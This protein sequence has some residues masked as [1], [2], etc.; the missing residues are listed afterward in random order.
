MLTITGI[1]VQEFH[2]PKID[3]RYDSS[4][5]KYVDGMAHGN[6]WDTPTSPCGIK[7]MPKLELPSSFDG[8]FYITQLC[9]LFEFSVLLSNGERSSLPKLDYPIV[10]GLEDHHNQI[11]K[12]SQ[13]ESFHW[14]NGQQSER[15]Y[16]IFCDSP[17]APFRHDW[18]ECHYKIQFQ[19]NF[20]V[21]SGE[22]IHK[23]IRLLGSF[24]WDLD[25]LL[26]RNFDKWV[27]KEN[28]SN[29]SSTTIEDSFTLYDYWPGIDA[30]EIHEL[31]KIT[32]PYFG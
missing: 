9:Q 7:V 14:T 18:I 22:T 1:E 19:T 24:K 13:G 26:K 27:V 17:W 8:F 2:S 20:Q 31:L 3:N 6:P 16:P 10:D 29:C 28:L 21:S 12:V 30:R 5:N 25:V 32:K 23:D 15:L 4:L 11:F